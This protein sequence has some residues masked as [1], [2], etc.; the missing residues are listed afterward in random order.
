MVVFM[1]YKSLKYN[2]IYI[3]E[4]IDI[5]KTNGSKKCDICHYCYFKGIGFKY[6]PY[7]CNGCYDL[8]QKPMNFDDVAIVSVKGSDY[9]IAFIISCFH[10]SNLL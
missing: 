8:M 4:R 1:N 10:W 7:L 9:R 5:N 3:S 6:E 2:R